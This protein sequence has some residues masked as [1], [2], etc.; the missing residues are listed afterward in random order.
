MHISKDS[1]NTGRLS[2]V[3]AFSSILIP[4]DSITNKSAGI[5]SPIDIYIISPTNKSSDFVSCFVLF[6]IV[7]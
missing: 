7:L 1:F 2:P 4:F 6:L 3:K 5:V